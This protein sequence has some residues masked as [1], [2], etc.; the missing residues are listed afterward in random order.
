MI[1][2]DTNAVNLLPHDGPRADIIRKLRQSGHHRVAVPWMVLE[3]MAAHQAKHYP[4]KYQ[5]VMNSLAKLR[6]VLPWELK[7]TLEPLDVE[8]LLN[9]WRGLYGDIFEVIETSGE[10]ARRALAREAMA[11]PPAKRGGDHSE[12]A[13]DV[14]IWFSILE[15]LKENPDEQVCFVTNNTKDFGNGVDYPYPMNED[16]EGLQDRITRLSDFDAVVSAFTKTVSGKDAEAVADELLRSLPVRSGV[17]QTAVE[18]LASVSGFVGLGPADTAIRWSGWFASPEVELLAVTDVTGHEI[19][20][21]VWYTANARWLLYGLAFDGDEANPGYTACVWETKVLFSARDGDEMPTLLAPKDPETPDASDPASIE[22]LNRLKTRVAGVTRRAMSEWL[23]G[24]SA[25]ENLFSKELLDSLDVAGS[26]RRSYSEALLPQRDIA[27]FQRSLGEQL[28]QSVDL[29][30][31][32][33]SMSER[34]LANIDF[35][36]VRRSLTASMPKLD[37]A[38][39]LPRIDFTGIA[40]VTGAAGDDVDDEEDD[41]DGQ[42]SFDDDQDDPDGEDGTPDVDPSKG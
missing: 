8:R 34:L 31:L 3:E 22:I 10:V 15:F 35:D 4:A 13:R 38:A 37:I 1:I 27:A 9:H 19:E 14:A 7:S 23:Q 20:G 18:V 41:L 30:G 16:V 6:E 25:A 26:L 5:T 33:R 11:L 2:F 17:A 12:G 32:N 29:T 28:A 40:G 36:G 21:D 39:M 24:T 42:L